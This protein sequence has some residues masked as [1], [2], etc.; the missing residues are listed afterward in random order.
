MNEMEMKCQ[1]LLQEV[2]KW[3]NRAVEAAEHACFN[4]EEYAEKRNCE[5]C[6]MRDILKEGNDDEQKQT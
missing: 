5:R 4:C 6:R 3:K 1:G 2:A